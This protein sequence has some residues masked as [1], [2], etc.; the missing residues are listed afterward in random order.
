MPATSVVCP[1]CHTV[2]QSASAI[3]A[4]KRIKC[5][6]CSNIFSPKAEEEEEGG[7]YGF[8]SDEKPAA[9]PPPRKKPRREEDED[10]EEEPVR[11]AAPRNGRSKPRRVERHE[12]EDDDRDYDEEEEEERPR[13]VRARPKFN[14]KPKKKSGTGLVV[15]LILGVTFLFLLAGGAVGGYVFLNWNK[16][17]GTGEEDLL[18]YVPADSQVIMGFDLNTLMSQ[19][20]LASV[21]DVIKSGDSDNTLEACRKQTGLEYKDLFGRIVIAIREPGLNL[22]TGTTGLTMYTM[23]S[24]STAPFN[25]NKIRKGMREPSRKSFDRKTYFQINETPFTRLFMPSDR[26]IL[27]ST[28][29]DPEMEKLIGTEGTK[30]GLSPNALNLIREIQQDHFWVAIPTDGL[31]GGGFFPAEVGPGAP[32]QAEALAAAARKLQG[33]TFR[34]NVAGSQAKLNLALHFSDGEAAKSATE[35]IQGIWDNQ[36]KPLGGLGLAAVPNDV[37]PLV[38]QLIQN[39]QF[40]TLGTQSQVNC[41][42]TLEALAKA[43]QEIPKQRQRIIQRLEGTP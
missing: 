5:P 28:V 11:R 25:Q 22:R 31:M 30:P 21:R 14:K 3:P 1:E 6:K 4:G 12:E 36:I 10:E 16:N 38:E 18:A 33:I 24:R 7:S 13:V 2:L 43:L 20:S 34:A 27:L 40:A 15:A 17:R 41:D 8:Q 42:I 39:A 35:S 32:P 23:V 37:R 26:T 9:P 29:G 19:P